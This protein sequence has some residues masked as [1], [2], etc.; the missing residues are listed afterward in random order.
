MAKI[1]SGT[2][3][4]FELPFGFG[5]AYCKLV[6]FSNISEYEGITLKVFDYFEKE[7]I[8]DPIFFK[9]MPLFMNPIPIAKMPSIRGKY[10]WKTLGILKEDKDAEIPI[11]KR[12]VNNGFAWE[13][14]EEYKSREW[15]ALVDL[16]KEVGPV[17]FDKVR[18]LEELFIRSTITIEERV[19]MTLLRAKGINVSDFF[20]KNCDDK[21]WRIDY[22]T[23]QFIPLYKRIP[24][25]IRG[26]PLIKGFVPDEYL[27][28]DWDSIKD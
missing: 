20:S 2:I 4:K 8:I 12:Y 15:F 9:D 18:H 3:F 24:E 21:V 27:N 10:A 5:S 1:E 28:F 17:H 16:K 14:I 19:V 11:H 26:K 25:V 22:K 6:D 23:Q 13:T 7:D